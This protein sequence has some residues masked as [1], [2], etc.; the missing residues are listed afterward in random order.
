MVA[1]KVVK[2]NK[3]G[4]KWIEEP[5]ERVK[6]RNRCNHSRYGLCDE[7]YNTFEYDSKLKVL[8]ALIGCTPD[9]DCPRMIAWDK[10]HGLE[11]P[12]TMV[13]NKGT[14]LKVTI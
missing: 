8:S 2:R 10:K 11:K 1:F 6:Y 12:Y 14:E 5:I 7:G 3:Y 9:V 4:H 13:E